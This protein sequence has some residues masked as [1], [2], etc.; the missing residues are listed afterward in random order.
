MVSIF[1]NE[2]GNITKLNELLRKY[3]KN[4]YLIAD[5]GDKNIQDSS[6]VKFC[7]RLQA[8]CLGPGELSSWDSSVNIHYISGV[9][10]IRCRKPRQ[11]SD[12]R[13]SQN[14]PFQPSRSG[15]D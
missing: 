6:K 3:V 4:Y 8:T 1:Y 12:K 5:L 13:R 10:P 11:P 14:R 2:K 7:N 9:R 15:S